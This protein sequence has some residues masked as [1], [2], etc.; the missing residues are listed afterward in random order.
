MLRLGSLGRDLGEIVDADLGRVKRA[1]GE[2]DLMHSELAARDLAARLRQPDPSFRGRG[3]VGAAEAS[4]GAVAVH[5]GKMGRTPATRWT[6]PNR[7]PSKIWSASRRTTPARSE[8]EQALAG[9]ISDE[10]LKEMRDDARHHAETI[11]DAVR[12]LPTVG[13]GSDSW[14]SKGAAARELPSRWLARSKRCARRGGAERTKLA[15][16]ARRGQEDPAERRLAGGP[17][18][19]EQ[20]RLEEVRR[21]LDAE[22]K[23]PRR[24]CSRRATRSRAGAKAAG[25]GGEEEGKLADRARDLGQR[26]GD[27]G[28]APRAGG[29]IHRGGRA[30]RAASGTR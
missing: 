30:S 11:R 12:E 9:A 18:G 6:R 17:N 22:E 13:L 24:R 7:R 23:W 21:K 25:R 14:T 16:L 20:A 26:A 4:R 1:R 5:R 10:E 29:G 2:S 19:E 15:R 3:R 27:K 8:M 28:S